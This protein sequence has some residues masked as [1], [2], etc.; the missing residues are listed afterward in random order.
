M[1]LVLPNFS[2]FP[3]GR[4]FASDLTCLEVFNFSDKTGTVLPLDNISVV[5]RDQLHSWSKQVQLY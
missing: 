2:L 4:A 3:L 1:E 5:I